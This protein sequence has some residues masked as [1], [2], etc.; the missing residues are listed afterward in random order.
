MNVNV[1]SSECAWFSADIKVLGRSLKG[2][3]AYEH[4]KS[5]EKEALYG[6]GQHALDI[7]SGNISCSG[8]ITVLGYELAEMNL[9]AQ[10]A[11]YDDILSIPH[12]A[13]VITVTYRKTLV[14]PIETHVCTGVS[15]SEI[16]HSQS[17]NDKK[18][19]IALPFICMDIQSR[20]IKV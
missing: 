8:S 18:R 14:D 7:Q 10:A 16:K 4:T 19:E 12:E 17:Q 6:A 11:G 5:V 3:T 15:F 13:V 20:L 2:V 9:A 1:R